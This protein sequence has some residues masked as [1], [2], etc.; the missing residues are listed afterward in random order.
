MDTHAYIVAIVFI[1][2]KNHILISAHL[3]HGV[4]LLLVPELL[5]VGQRKKVTAVT[6]FS[7]RPRLDQRGTNTDQIRIV[8]VHEIT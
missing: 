4:K 6:F 3:Q 8:P 5:T 2:A 1:Y 7:A